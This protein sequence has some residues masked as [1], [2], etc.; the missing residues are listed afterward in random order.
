MTHPALILPMRDIQSVMG[1]VFH[2]PALLL[3]FQPLLGAQFPWVSRT[4]QPGV[5]QLTLGANPPI[6]PGDLQRSG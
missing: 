4:D 6:D 5:R 2:A 1:S 3:Q